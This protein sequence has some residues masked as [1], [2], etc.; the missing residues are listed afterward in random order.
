MSESLE[1]II[2]AKDQASATFKSIGKSMSGAFKMGAIGAGIGLGVLGAGMG[3]LISQGMEGERVQAALNAVIKSTGGVAGW[4]AGEANSLADSLSRV[5]KF[6]ADTV[7]ETQSLLLTFTKIGEDIMPR[8]T[9]SVLN[10]ATVF[11]ST[12]SAAI[13]LGKALNDPI[14]GI[15]ALSRVGVSF[16]EEQKKMVE[17][18]VKA[19]DVAGA[20]ALILDELEIE[21][22][23]AARAAGDTF[24]GKL[25]ILKNKMMDVVETIGMMMMPA[26]NGILDTIIDDLLPAFEEFGKS[27]QPIFVSLST[28]IRNFMDVL[29]GGGSLNDALSDMLSTGVRGS[30]IFKRFLKN[31]G[32]TADQ[33]E[34]VR[35]KFIQVQGI[36]NSV[37][38]VFMGLFNKFIKPFIDK[39]SKQFIK[40]IA[41]MGAV[42][43]GG[44]LIGGIIT[45]AATIAGALA[46]LLN[47]FTYLILAVGALVLAWETDFLGM[48]SFLLPIINELTE[49]FISQIPEAI[50]FVT[51][52]WNDTLLPAIAT[53]AEFWTSTLRPAL[54][55]LWEW[56]KTQIPG[57]IETLKGIW[58]SI[59]MPA[60]K[61]YVQYWTEFLLPAFQA[62]AN[63]L[64]INIPVAIAWLK[65]AWENTLLPALQKLNT[66]WTETLK[67]ALT[68]LVTWL[69]VNIPIAIAWLKGI[70]ENVLIPALNSLV[71]LW[72]ETLN[73]ILQELWDWLYTYIGEA[74]D[75]LKVFISDTLI[76]AFN[77]IVNFWNET[78]KPALTWL[79][80]FLAGLVVLA[81]GALKLAIDEVLIPAFNAISDFWTDTLKPVMEEIIDHVEVKITKAIDGAKIAFETV[82]KPA[83]EAIKD[84]WDDN[85]K[86]VVASIIG[87]FQVAVP[88]ALAWG[89]LAF[90]D[91]KSGIKALLQPINDVL[92]AVG[93]LANAISNLGSNI[94]SILQ[95]GSPTPFEIGLRGISSAMQ[96]LDNVTARYDRTF[97]NSAIGKTDRSGGGQSQTTRNFNL[98]LNGAN[99]K[100]ERIRNDFN[101]LRTWEGI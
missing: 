20:Q 50:E 25:I 13:Q 46:V 24:G 73:P 34:G 54:E 37:L 70:W 78:L 71:T 15:G 30:S 9:E 81:I 99:T 63:W 55:E 27:I 12:D 77:S 22:G 59:L 49:W 69:L 60:I 18:M 82:L 40:A 68:D 31:L 76:P 41:A 1:I 6:S 67:P 97:Q 36:V 26:F 86:P 62:L 75:T 61:L 7:I 88:I 21:F 101:I 16:T 3:L 95:P 72:D 14:A 100:N 66:F 94:P 92:G 23:D 19:G 57:A 10:M 85:L 39:Y 28:V 74:I 87:M 17:E 52:L 98:Y 35:K 58:E 4:S 96:D 80:F 2:V 64:I 47:P 11:G 8:A 89:K 43:I 33:A 5:T 51:N 44:T 48:R 42:L 90:D 56:F 93:D 79:A 84:Y 53:L 38:N 83:M 29:V 45:F 91:L 65:N 32:L